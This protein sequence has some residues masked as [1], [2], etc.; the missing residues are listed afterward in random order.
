[1][2]VNKANYK[3]SV[4]LRLINLETKKNHYQTGQLWRINYSVT[5]NKKD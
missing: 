1:V 5:F 2:F 3:S 4:D